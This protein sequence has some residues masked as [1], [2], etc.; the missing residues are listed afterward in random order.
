MVQVTQVQAVHPVQATA[1]IRIF[2][3]KVDGCTENSSNCM[4]K[5]NDPLSIGR[6]LVGKLLQLAYE[7][8]LLLGSAG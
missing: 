4:V 5:S 1:S 3:L 8:L 2:Q 7:C 6:L